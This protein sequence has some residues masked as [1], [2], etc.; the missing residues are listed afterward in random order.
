[1]VAAGP[2]ASTM[3]SGMFK[4]ILIMLLISLNYTLILLNTTLVSPNY[5]FNSLNYP[6]SPVRSAVGAAHAQVSLAVVHGEA[7][8]QTGRRQKRMRGLLM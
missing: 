3:G 5:T 4:I 7:G 1:M 2:V 8:R 6:L